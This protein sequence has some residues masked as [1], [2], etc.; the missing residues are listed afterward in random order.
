MFLERES[1]NC[2]PCMETK[3]K[4]D[5]EVSL[6][7]FKRWKEAGKVW[8]IAVIDFGWVSS[9]IL[10]SKFKVSRVKV[11]WVVGYGPNE[12]NGEERERFWNDLDRILVRV[13]DYAYQE[14]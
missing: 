7:V 1:L 11:C 4:G 9:R 13:G 8:H 2:L 12:G 10:W 14:T 6:L 3:L 5:G